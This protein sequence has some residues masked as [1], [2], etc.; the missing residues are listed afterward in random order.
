LVNRGRHA[1]GPW[2]R[3]Y[4]SI[5]LNNRDLGYP[6]RLPCFAP[7]LSAPF[8][9]ANQRQIAHLK[10]EAHTDV[11]S[12]S[13]IGCRTST[14]CYRPARGSFR[15]LATASETLRRGET[16]LMKRTPSLTLAL[17]NCLLIATMAISVPTLISRISAE[18][19]AVY[20][21]WFVWGVWGV[22]LL[23]LF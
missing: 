18:N 2:P 21:A 22:L 12:H 4:V 16:R 9:C 15:A 11:G 20:D 19:S 1:R 10:A 5:S 14:C 17:T 7:V 6:A 3:S 23:C 13:H 8:S